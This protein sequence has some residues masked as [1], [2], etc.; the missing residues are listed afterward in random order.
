MIELM[1]LE[2][3]VKSS[4]SVSRS[5]VD[6]SWSTH[7]NLLLAATDYQ[8]QT[9]H[10]QYKFQS[11]CWLTRRLLHVRATILTRNSAHDFSIVSLCVCSQTDSSYWHNMWCLAISGRKDLSRYLLMRDKP[12]FVQWQ[13]SLLLA[14]A[15]PTMMNHLTSSPPTMHYLLHLFHVSGKKPFNACSW[16]LHRCGYKMIALLY[17]ALSINVTSSC[18]REEVLLTLAAGVFTDVVTNDTPSLH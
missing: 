6:W 7:G 4:A 10:R 1:H 5:G 3:E 2:L 16:C 12:C 13:I 17:H 18:F 14:Q 9:A 15:R 8:R 11:Q